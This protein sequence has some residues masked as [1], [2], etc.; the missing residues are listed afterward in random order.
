MQIA[1]ALYPALTAL[2]IVG[3]FNVLAYGPGVEPVFVAETLEP[4][5]VDVG[6][7]R[8]PPNATFDDC[9]SPD[10][11]VVPGGPGSRRIAELTSLTSWLRAVHPTTTYTTSVCTG[12]FALAAA[13]ILDGK[14]ATTHWASLDRLAEHGAVPVAERVV[15]DGKIVTGAG[16]AA[17]IDMALTLASTLWGDE[18]A[19]SIQLG[20]EYDPQPPFTTG[21]PRTAPPD[22]IER[23]RGLVG[24]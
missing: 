7:L 17:G 2:D 22:M 9:P 21:S 6:A 23:M 16:V 1:F 4:V 8:L 19:Q 11:V 18:V 15:I 13:G 24:A 20:I 12:A 10:V 14:R 5:T 3:P